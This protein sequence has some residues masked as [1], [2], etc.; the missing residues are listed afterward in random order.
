MKFFKLTCPKIQM[1]DTLRPS[2]LLT[3]VSY[4]FQHHQ[5][6]ETFE[7]DDHKMSMSLPENELQIF[8]DIISMDFFVDNGK[9]TN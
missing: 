2:K 1:L 4:N 8:L 5:F 7:L 3:P 6:R 9:P